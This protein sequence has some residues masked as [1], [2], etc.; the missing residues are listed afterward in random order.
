MFAFAPILA[1]L[2]AGQSAFGYSQSI[3]ENIHIDDPVGQWQNYDFIE[4][5]LIGMGVRSVRS[6]LTILPGPSNAYASFMTKLAADGITSD[7]IVGPNITT[8]AQI[9]T[10]LSY[11]PGVISLEGPNE[12]DIC[13]NDSAWIAHDQATTAAMA[14]IHGE[15]PAMTIIAPS[16]AS[17]DPALLGNLAGEVQSGNMH[18]YR[19]SFI[20]ESLGW[21]G[22]FY[23]QVY[24][25]LA[26]NIAAAQRSAVGLP[27]ISTEESYTTGTVS[28]STQASYDERFTLWAYM[29]GIL[30]QYLYDL[31]DDSE[32][33]GVARLDGSLKPSAY[34][35]Q[36]LFRILADSQPASGMCS[37]DVSITTTVPYDALLLCKSNG[38]QDLVLWQPAQLQDPQTLA[39]TPATPAPV[40]VTANTTGP[41][42]V[43]LQSASYQWS[44]AVPTSSGNV[45]GRLTERPLIIAFHAASPVVIPPLPIMGTGLIHGHPIPPGRIHV[46]PGA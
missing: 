29:H 45:S 27:V 17:N 34:G 36:G 4:R 16:V 6:S 42:I 22:V 19:G 38:E 26:Y 44:N 3:G 13:C 39:S 21:G 10:L 5:L 41:A 43:Y 37:L 8:T 7:N 31:L 15:N 23:G 11:A 28:E 14:P 12:Q 33:F 25:S 1:T 30:K 46:S 40:T 20:P 9:Q 2:I 32:S 35:L 24:G 18:P